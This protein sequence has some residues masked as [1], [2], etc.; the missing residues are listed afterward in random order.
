MASPRT[1]LFKGPFCR[2]MYAKGLFTP[3]TYGNDKD[4]KPKFN[5]SFVFE[6]KDKPFFEPYLMEVLKEMTDGVK[7]FKA[8]L[9][10]NPLIRGDGPEAK[11]KDGDHA[12]EIKPGL[13]KGLFF[14][15]PTAQPDSP[16]SV[17]FRDKNKQETEDVVYSGCYGKP[18]LNVYAW[19][20]GKGISFGISGFQRI[21]HPSYGDGERLF[22]GGKGDFS[23]DKWNETIADEGPVPEAAKSGGGAASLFGD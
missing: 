18:I 22:S 9:I 11:Y 4:A 3:G 15:R 21:P 6:D 2:L 8:E 13:G 16:P 1:E 14:I 12:G 19:K 7:R 20:D 5:P 10:K 23:A 17:W